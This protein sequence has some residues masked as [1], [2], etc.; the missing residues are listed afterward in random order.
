MSQSTNDDAT[1]I[2]PE[3]LTLTWVTLT[4]VMRNYDLLSH[5]WASLVEARR[6]IEVEVREQ[7]GDDAWASMI[8]DNTT[9]PAEER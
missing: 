6:L 1:Q 7:H 9:T 5:G 2:S 4:A 3:A 8:D